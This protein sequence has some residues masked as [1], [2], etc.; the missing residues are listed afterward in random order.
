MKPS[1]KKGI[2]FGLTSGVITT[3][4]VVVG[5][6]SATESSSIV[7]SGILVIAIADALSDALGIH[8][9]EESTN[10]HNHHE[11]WESTLYTFLSKFFIAL[12]FVIPVLLFSIHFAIFASI[13]W[14][15]FLIT[16][17]SYYISKQQ[18][19]KP[20]EVIAEHLLITVAVIVIT[21]YVGGFVGSIS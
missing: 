18:G 7:L 8:I 4:G 19:I 13:L 6:D 14:G 3:L 11:V 2:S 16:T 15:L 5:L 20:F 21:Y 9:S 1:I 12:T 10:G 17:L